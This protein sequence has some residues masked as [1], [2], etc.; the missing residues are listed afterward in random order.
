MATGPEIKRSYTRPLARPLVEPA[1]ALV[2][3][4]WR[5]VVLFLVLPLAALAAVY[6]WFGGMVPLTAEL[7][8]APLAVS[9][10]EVD[11]A[12][13]CASGAFAE[14]RLLWGASAF[15]L[16]AI[17]A[18]LYAYTLYSMRPYFESAYQVAGIAL[19]LA[20]VAAVPI[21]VYA[22]GERTFHSVFPAAFTRLLEAASAAC[23]RDALAVSLGPLALR[24]SFFDLFTA[25]FHVFNV[26]V[27][28]PAMTVGACIAF[29]IVNVNVERSDEEFLRKQRYRLRSFLYLTSIMLILGVVVM[30]SWSRWPAFGFDV[31]KE[32]IERAGAQADVALAERKAR[33]AAET[34]DE[35]AAARDEKRAAAEADLA[36][37]KL[38]ED[39]LVA[40]RWRKGLQSAAT[41]F[42][43]YFGAMYT[44]LLIMMFVPAARLLDRVARERAMAEIAKLKAA[45]PE[46]DITVDQWLKAKDMEVTVFDQIK[47]LI[48]LLAPLAAGPLLEIVKGVPLA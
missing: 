20:I 45:K 28:L 25:T 41:G 37:K 30:Q 6:L 21:G 26:I 23:L 29:T 17:G 18:A 32:R 16:V 7:R 9:G 5:H 42:T 19:I 8:A 3:V 34:A 13:L 35:K 44:L 27:V 11:A 4:H 31:L 12:A 2:A 48:A 47:P 10:L 39:A 40:E 15:L 46:A 36:K 38:A 1:H 33:I 43:V 24:A 14:Q 22:A